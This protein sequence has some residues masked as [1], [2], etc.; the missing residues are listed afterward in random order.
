[1]LVHT[2]NTRNTRIFESLSIFFYAVTMMSGSIQTNPLVNLP[3]MF[4][5]LEV[6]EFGAY[7]DR[8]A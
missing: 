1:M 8:E 7:A 5:R 3:F 6:F 2:L 4:T